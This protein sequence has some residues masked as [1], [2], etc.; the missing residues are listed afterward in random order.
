MGKATLSADPGDGHRTGRHRGTPADG[1]RW[2]PNLLL[3]TVRLLL[4]T[5]GAQRTTGPRRGHAMWQVCGITATPP[6]GSV[7]LAQTA[8]LD[9]DRPPAADP[10]GTSR[11]QRRRDDAR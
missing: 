10:R 8:P 2:R 1:R 3:A 9:V 4:G 7:P 6:G 5:A 11:E